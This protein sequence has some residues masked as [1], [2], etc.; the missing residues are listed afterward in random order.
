MKLYELAGSYTR[1]RDLLFS[2]DSGGESSPE[3]ETELGAI[4][5]A[6]EEKIESIALLAIEMQAEI[7]GIKK[8]EARITGR[9]KAMVNRRASLLEYMRHQMTTADI[10]SV[11]RP[12]VS[13]S[14]QQSG[15]KVVVDDESAIP[16]A[17]WVEKPSALNK[18]A[19]AKEL[20]KEG[21]AVAGCRL[22]KE[23]SIRIR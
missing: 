18:S 3:I 8:E 1:L 7:D 16:A 17:F 10:V 5:D 15:G 6:I 11:K 21:G 13:V 22:V 9:S 4:T 2:M 23:S 12:R 19:I 14:L 20:K